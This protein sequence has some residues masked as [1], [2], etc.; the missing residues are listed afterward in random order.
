MLPCHLMRTCCG[1]CCRGQTAP[2][3]VGQPSHIN[4]IIEQQYKLAKY[5]NPVAKYALTNITSNEEWEMYDLVNDPLETTNLANSTYPRTAEQQL[6]FLAMKARLA[7]VERTR[8]ASLELS[9]PVNLMGNLCRLPTLS[10]VAFSA[11]YFGSLSG[12]PTG[13]GS[14]T[15]AMAADGTPKGLTVYSPI[16]A[17]DAAVVLNEGSA[18]SDSWTAKAFF[19]TGQGVFSAVSGHLDLVFAKPLLGAP[20]CANVTYQSPNYCYSP[21]QCPGSFSLTG[22][23]RY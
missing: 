14:I 19:T 13:N 18:I 23:L 7:V 11:T 15:F 3:T 4:A 6:Q 9:Y 17:M 1:L 5:Y 16:G 21:S 8:L 2:V 22:T 10:A 12:I 20:V